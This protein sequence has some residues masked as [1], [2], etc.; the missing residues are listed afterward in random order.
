MVNHC[1]KN[2]KLLGKGF[3]MIPPNSK[4]LWSQSDGIIE[5]EKLIETIETGR[6]LTVLFFIH[7]M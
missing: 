6:K 7:L 5:G 3:K 1:F 2:N 4:M